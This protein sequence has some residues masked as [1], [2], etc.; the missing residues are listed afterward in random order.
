MYEHAQYEEAAH[1]LFAVLEDRQRL[2]GSV[3]TE[4][5]P[6]YNNLAA[7]YC[8]LKDLDSAERM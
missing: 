7:C 4:T 6:V 3:A 8:K 1:V 2:F 5:L